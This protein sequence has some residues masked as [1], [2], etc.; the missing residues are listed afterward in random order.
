MLNIIRLSALQTSLFSLSS[1]EERKKRE[2]K[3]PPMARHDYRKEWNE[4]AS[5]LLVGKTIK[6]VGYLSAK[7]VD[8]LGWHQSTLAIELDDGTVFWASRD[9][10]GNGAGVLFTSNEALPTIPV[11]PAN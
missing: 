5:K 3:E 2:R 10:E 9:D 7:E 11:L 8:D 4:A 6:K 1:Y